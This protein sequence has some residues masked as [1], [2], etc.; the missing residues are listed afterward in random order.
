[1]S[2]VPLYPHQAVH[3]LYRG[4]SLIR[5]SVPLCSARVKIAAEAE[6]LARVLAPAERKGDTF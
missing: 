6:L 2:E 4:T 1:M 5:N 3:C